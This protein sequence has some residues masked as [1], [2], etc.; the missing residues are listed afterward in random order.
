[1]QTPLDLSRHL[2]LIR[3]FQ[4]KGEIRRI[5]DVAYNVFKSGFTAPDVTEG[6]TEVKEIQFTP[7]FVN[8]KEKMLFQQWTC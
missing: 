7:K 3:M 8:N 2:N 5:P 1:M 6:F 4:T